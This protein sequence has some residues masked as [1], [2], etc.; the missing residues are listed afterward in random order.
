MKLRKLRNLTLLLL[1]AV[2]GCASRQPLPLPPQ[3]VI[4]PPI[5]PDV[6]CPPLPAYA[7]RDFVDVWADAMIAHGVCSESLKVWQESHAEC[8]EERE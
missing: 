1:F 6:E 5:A 3:R 7:D 2:G 8:K 4:C